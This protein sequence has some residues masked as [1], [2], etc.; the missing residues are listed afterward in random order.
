MKLQTV[1]LGGSA[2][3]N[4]VSGRGQTSGRMKSKF[5]P[6]G[7]CTTSCGCKPEDEVQEDERRPVRSPALLA[8]R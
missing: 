6:I 2:S 3:R 4:L 1:A 5:D 8:V 7:E